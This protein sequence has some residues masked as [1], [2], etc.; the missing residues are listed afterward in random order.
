MAQPVKKNVD[1]VTIVVTHH[2]QSVYTPTVIELFELVKELGVYKQEKKD[3]SDDKEKPE[4]YS[5]SVEAFSE[6]AESGLYYGYTETAKMMNIPPKK[7][8]T[9]GDISQMILGEDEKPVFANYFIYNPTKHLLMYEVNRN[10]CS[11]NKLIEMMRVAYIR[12]S[13]EL[14]DRTCHEDRVAIPKFGEYIKITC[15]GVYRKE[16]YDRLLNYKRFSQIYLE[17]PCAQVVL[18]DKV[19]ENDSFENGIKKIMQNAHELNAP[20]ATMILDAAPVSESISGLTR[21]T[22]IRY[23]NTVRKKVSG[24]T[25]P[26]HLKVQGYYTDADSGRNRRGT[27][28]FTEDFFDEH[29][30]IPRKMLHDDL[31][32]QDRKIGMQKVYKKIIGE[33]NEMNLIQ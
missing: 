17:I 6:D 23:V 18:N 28:D 11:I 19:D 14:W 16:A 25:R 20:K 26:I 32:L 22:V 27:V 24:A 9:S 33:I 5:F 2:M 13:H 3:S 21:D 15:N 7:N 4:E 8:L 10:G 1:V 31:Q 12:K 30:Y 29:F